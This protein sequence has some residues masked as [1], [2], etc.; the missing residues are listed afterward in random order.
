V[1]L[2]RVDEV[3]LAAFVVVVTLET[4]KAHGRARAGHPVVEASIAH[5]AGLLVRLLQAEEVPLA[6]FPVV[7]TPEATMAVA[8]PGALT[9]EVKE[10]VAVSLE[11][12]KAAGALEA[13]AAEVKEEVMGEAMEEVTGK[14]KE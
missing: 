5:Q 9:G 3:P 2:L 11:I 7:V 1:R 10:E 13:L 14:L 6:A 8:A 4:S 12:S